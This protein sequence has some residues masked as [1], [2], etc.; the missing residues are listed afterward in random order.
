MKTKLCG[1]TEQRSLQVA[2][3]QKCDFVGFVFCVDSMRYIDL[4]KAAQLA[5]IVPA[6][7]AKVAVVVDEDWQNLEKIVLHLRPDFV[8][9]HGAEDENYLQKFRQNFP[10]IGIIKAFR[11]GDKTDLAAVNNFAESADFFLFDALKAGSGKAFD[12]SLLQGFNAQRPWFLSGGI[13]VFNVAEAVAK[14][15]AKMVDVSSG[16]EEVRGQ[17]SS[18]LI[19]QFMNKVNQLC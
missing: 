7:I 13:N 15:N 18:R 17:K 9:F 2:I 14:T 6:D 10:K 3:E 1:F 4:Q 12:W 5:K 11:I 8:Q 19:K 16:I